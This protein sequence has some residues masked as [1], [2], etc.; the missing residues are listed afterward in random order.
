M[1]SGDGAAFKGVQ[2]LNAH[3]SPNTKM[4]TRQ[5]ERDLGMNG[6]VGLRSKCAATLLATSLLSLSEQSQT[7]KSE[8]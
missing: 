5:G 2:Q 4:K 1:L 3:A 7:I 8:V 6:P